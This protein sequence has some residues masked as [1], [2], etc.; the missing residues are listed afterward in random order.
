M[1][2]TKVVIRVANVYIKRH[3]WDKTSLETS[4]GRKETL[5]RIQGD[6]KQRVGKALRFLL[7]LLSMRHRKGEGIHIVWVQNEWEGDF[8]KPGKT[9][10]KV[11]ENAGIKREERCCGKDRKRIRGT[12]KQRSTQGNFSVENVSGRH[13]K[14]QQRRQKQATKFVSEKSETKS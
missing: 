1:L 3:W 7:C 14:Q 6:V 12:R 9:R 5:C 4:K 13:K 2:V 10:H 8:V 11:E